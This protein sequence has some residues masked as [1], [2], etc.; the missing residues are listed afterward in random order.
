MFFDDFYGNANM[1]EIFFNLHTVPVTYHKKALK[2]HVGTVLSLFVKVLARVKV[3]SMF[4]LYNCT[5]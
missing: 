2:F 3:S 1:E 4:S 5:K